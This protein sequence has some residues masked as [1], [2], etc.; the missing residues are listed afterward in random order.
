MPSAIPN[1][2]VAGPGHTII[3]PTQLF[4]DQFQYNVPASVPNNPAQLLSSQTKPGDM[5]PAVS[6]GPQISDPSPFPSGTA[7][8]SNIQFPMEAYV[9]DFNTFRPAAPPAHAPNMFPSQPHLLNLHQFNDNQPTPMGIPSMPRPLGTAW[10]Q[11]APEN[12]FISQPNQDSNSTRWPIPSGSIQNNSMVGISS[13][14]VPGHQN[15]AFGMPPTV[16]FHSRPS[17]V[18]SASNMNQGGVTNASVAP[19]PMRSYSPLSQGPSAATMIAHSLINFAVQSQLIRRPVTAALQNPVYL[20]GPAPLPA[21]PALLRPLNESSFLPARPVTVMHPRMLFPSSGDFIFQP[22]HLQNSGAPISL[23]S[24]SVARNHP[25]MEQTMKNPTPFGI[26]DFPNQP[27]R[28]FFRSNLR[29][30]ADDLYDRFQPH[31]SARNSSD[32]VS[33]LSSPYERIGMRDAAFSLMESTSINRPHQMAN[34]HG[35]FLSRPGNDFFPFAHLVRNSPNIHP[36]S[37]QSLRPSRGEQ[38]Y[39]PFSPTTASALH[40]Q[41]EAGHYTKSNDHVM[42][43]SDI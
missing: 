15:T 35:S 14:P 4:P 41:Q 7:T 1:D 27:H 6:T 39:D 42:G 3:R 36:S 28:P 25:H 10:P 24:G 37:R 13:I 30:H 22:Q 19:P 32:V 2:I 23:W 18:L 38:A 33:G 5:V 11:P 20:P 43:N 34:M 9:S 26:S 8:Q 17:T 31:F 21:P 16:S 29:P 12:T 40:Q